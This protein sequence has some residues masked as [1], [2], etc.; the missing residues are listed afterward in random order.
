[1]AIKMSSIELKNVTID[2]PIY[3]SQGRSLKKTIMGVATGGRIGLTEKGNTIIRSL[4][5]ISLSISNRERVG[6]VGH[7]G[8]G[9]KYFTSC[10]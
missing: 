9:K 5:D 2:I 4:D 8:A 3:N 10:S 7:N 6:L 1:M